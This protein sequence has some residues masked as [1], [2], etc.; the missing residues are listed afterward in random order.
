LL[1]LHARYYDPAL[2][3][4][5]SADTIV[6][7]PGNPQDFNRYAYVRNNP[8]MYIDRDGHSAWPFIIVLGMIYVGGRVTY[9]AASLAFIDGDRRDQIGGQL[10][11]DVS[12]IIQHQSTSHSVDPSLVSAVLRHESAAVDR[13]LFTLWPTMQPGVIA[14][15]GEYVQSAL[16][17][18]SIGPMR[19]GDYASI[20]PGQMQLGLAREL[21]S[22]GYV[23]PRANDFERRCALLGNETSVEYVAGYL[24]Y[25]SDQLTA[26]SGFSELDV[27][28]QNRLILIGYNWG[29]AG[30][31]GL[32][33]EY[34]FE[35]TIAQVE[36]DNETWD[37]Y[38]WW[39]G[40]Q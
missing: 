16:P 22:W 11:T 26:L 35:Y 13:R 12:E 39:N 29:W 34:G 28:T 6:P 5:I 23:T 10:V 37:A 9:E 27:E 17:E 40:G 2:G 1:F 33:E 30:L 31:S 32:I 25:L 20:G 38:E 3:R 4:F 19:I 7:E 18:G 21:E 24:H 36:Y 15:A 8:T 14:N